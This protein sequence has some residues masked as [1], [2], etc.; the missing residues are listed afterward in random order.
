VITSSASKHLPMA[1]HSSD[2]GAPALADLAILINLLSLRAG[3]A[4]RPT[5][6]D[7]VGLDSDDLVEDGNESSNV[8]GSVDAADQDGQQLPFDR[9][10]R[11]FLDRIAEVFAAERNGS[12]VAAAV[13]REVE[14]ED[15]VDIWVARN[16]GF[17][18]DKDKEMIIA[19]ELALNKLARDEDHDTTDL[20]HH[21]LRYSSQ[22]LK[23]YN[24]AL[25]K[26][27][28][29]LEKIAPDS[30]SQTDECAAIWNDIHS[31]F[32]TPSFLPETELSDRSA[33]SC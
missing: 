16:N 10:R 3:N 24:D 13:L 5:I 18:E 7:A 4:V 17:K 22:R 23:Y 27:L 11:R 25:M 26:I 21:M 20:R 14:R 32:F 28:A 31:H 8:G 9:L 30:T 6:S 19:T 15:H 29:P 1:H 12:F 2:R 33:S